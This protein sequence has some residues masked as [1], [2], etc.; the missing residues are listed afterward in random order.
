MKEVHQQRQVHRQK[1]WPPE[2][3]RNLAVPATSPANSSSGTK[4]NLADVDHVQFLQSRVASPSLK[5]TPGGSSYSRR[6]NKEGRSWPERER[7]REI[8]GTNS[9]QRDSVKKKTLSVQPSLEPICSRTF[10]PLVGE[11]FKLFKIIICLFFLTNYQNHFLTTCNFALL[12]T[13]TETEDNCEVKK[14]PQCPKN[15]EVNQDL[16]SEN[17]DAS[18][19]GEQRYHPDHC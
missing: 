11:S 15:N 4:A 13:W 7:W 16:S 12:H 6:N 9:R 3:K 17:D 2:D 18:E 1:I 5:D 14:P 10:N 19:L 8:K